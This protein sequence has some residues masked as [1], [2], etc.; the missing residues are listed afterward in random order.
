MKADA[1]NDYK[2]CNC[3]KK[4]YIKN[5]RSSLFIGLLLA[6]LAKC[7]FCLVAYSSTVALCGVNASHTS[8]F[9]SI[10]Y[11]GILLATGLILIVLA[12][13]YFNKRDVRTKLAFYVALFGSSCIITS[14]I[15]SVGL[16]LY[17]SGIGILFVSIWMNGSMMHCLKKIQEIQKNISSFHYFNNF[18]NLKI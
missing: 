13:I 1:Y 16:T 9:C 7:P 3:N 12:S 15:F 11:P 4:M 17:Y 14:L 10:S 6:F 2:Q 8:T 18:L 5:K